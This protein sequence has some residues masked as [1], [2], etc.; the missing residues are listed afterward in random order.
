MVLQSV[1]SLLVLGWIVPETLS[2]TLPLENVCCS[3]PELALGTSFLLS[4]WFVVKTNCDKQDSVFTLLSLVRQSAFVTVVG[5]L[6][7]GR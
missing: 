6:L 2:R 4:N 7:T 3:M 1:I 5:L